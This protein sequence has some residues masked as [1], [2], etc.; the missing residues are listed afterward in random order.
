M[1]RGC[2]AHAIERTAQRNIRAEDVDFVF[3]FGQL[4]H[5]GGALFVFLGGRDIPDEFRMD[6]HFVRLEGTILILSHDG[7][8][9][10]TAYR[11]KKGLKDIRK[12]QKWFIPSCRAA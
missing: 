4:V 12:K 2:S 11:N 7:D 3:R 10:I 8:S 6:D 5:N 1:T 9:L